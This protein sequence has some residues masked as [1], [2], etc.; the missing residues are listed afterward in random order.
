[1]PTKVEK[2]SLTGTETTGH[3]WD[4]I[5]E[6][7]NPLPK[8]W[9]YVFYV[10][11]AWSLVY[12]V[13][14]PSIPGITGYFGGVLGADQRSALESKMDAARAAQADLYEA[15][16]ARSP[17]EIAADPNLATFAFAGGEAAYADNCAPCHG[18][19]GAGQANYPVLADDAWIWGGT[20]EAIQTTLLH[21]IRADNPDTRSSMMPAYGAMNILNR[22]QIDAVASHVLSLSGKVD[23]A[24]VPEEGRTV[25]EANC[26]ACHGAD[27]AG[28][29]ALG[30]PRLNDQVWLYGGTHEAVMAQITEPQ[31]GMMPAWQGRLDDETI[32]M[33]TVYVHQLG[34]GE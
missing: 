3:E 7:N 15:V 12:W 18:L 30:A 24:E 21:G 27:G 16:A 8:W 20:M 17:A 5:R 2:D 25:Y 33:L 29:S 28:N 4:G 10:T 11:I 19:G 26:V 23:P 13:L 31:H 1:M 22:E 14:Y 34:G 6:L 9:L 32:K